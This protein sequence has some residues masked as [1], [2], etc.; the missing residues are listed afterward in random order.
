MKKYSFFLLLFS[1]LQADILFTET[2]DNSGTWPTGWSFDQYINPETGEVYTSFGQHN[3]RIDNSFQSDPGF[4]PPAAVFYYFPR[5]PLPNDV[6]IGDT[7]PAE[8]GNDPQSEL[9]TSYELSMQSPDIDVG[10]NNAVLVEFTIALDYWDNPTAHINGMV[11]EADGGNG[12]S[13]M[14]K[15]EVGG[16]GAGDDFDA[17]LR[18]ETFVV[19]T[20]TGTLKLRWKAYGTDSYFIDAWIIDN[21]KVITLPKLSY[22]HIESDNTTDIQSAVEGNNVTLSF[23]SEQSLLTLPYVQINGFETTVIPQGGNSYIASYLVSNADA[24]GPLTF[25]IDFTALDGGIDG[26]TVKSTSDNS[27][28]T[29]D[30]TPPPPFNV[31]DIITTQGGNVFSGKWNSTNTGM[32]IDVTV[33]E[34]SAVVDFN[35]FQ[36]NSISFD[37][38]DDR[39]VINGNS[40]YKFSDQFTIELWIKPNSTDSDNY[41]GL[42]SFGEDGSNQFG[43]G[44][45][46]Y[47]TGWR[48]FIKTQSNSVSQWTSLPYASAPSGQWTHLAASY[49][50]TKLTLYKNG[51]V[52]DEKVVSGQIAWAA[53]SGDLYIGSF[54]KAGTDYFFNGT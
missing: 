21:L 10:D 41:R 49:D 37:G 11:I 53:N 44:F 24:D 6:S 3:W 40:I 18:T 12:W 42:I 52:A 34:D 9:E 35:Y 33:P 47:A 46:Y 28:V 7:H 50:G 51:S 32:E 1:F 15:Y 48:F 26:A 23:T 19:S 54:N 45:A 2:F 27:R 29:I 36:G 8:S 25:S 13:E 16:V 5:V 31:G 38:L 30:R 17:S 20:E 39:V 4:T 43:Y 22:T 14:L